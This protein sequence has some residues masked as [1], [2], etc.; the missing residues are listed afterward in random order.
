MNLRRGFKTEANAIAREIRHEL[1]L[2][3]DD[4]LD[5][6]AL[7]G[8]LDIPVWCLSDYQSEAPQ[9]VKHFTRV[10]QGV[11]SAIT[12]FDG[13]ARVIV[14]NDSHSRGRQASNLAHELS[15]GLLLHPPAPALDEGGCRDWD[16]TLESEATWLGGALLI[17][18]EAAVL[19]A[20]QGWTVSDAAARYGVSE[21]MMKWRLDITA[22]RTRVTRASRY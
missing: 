3:S 11:F 22:A 15:H 14:H 17:S 20:R 21:R 4:P 1:K 5:P 6:W 12:V 2:R 16:K 8:H 9:M 19:I 18:D 7:A 10:E 13:T